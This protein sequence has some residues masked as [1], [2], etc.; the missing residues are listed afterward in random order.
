MERNAKSLVS[1]GVSGG[2]P[3]KSWSLPWN[4]WFRVVGGRQECGL[5]LELFRRLIRRLAKITNCAVSDQDIRRVFELIDI[6]HT[7]YMTLEH[8]MIWLYG[9]NHSKTLSATKRSSKN[10]G[11]IIDV[12]VTL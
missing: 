1:G 4:T 12:T 3:T 5:S 6:N 11:E 8:L 9:Q 10:D 7:G 2:S